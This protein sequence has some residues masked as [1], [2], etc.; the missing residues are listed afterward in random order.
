MACSS[1]RCKEIL[2]KVDAA[3]GSS[4]AAMLT[5]AQFSQLVRLRDQIDRACHRTD[6]DEAVRLE[7]I[8]LAIIREGPPSFR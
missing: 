4:R 1:H 7:A 8:V 6:A 3:M 2:E 5:A